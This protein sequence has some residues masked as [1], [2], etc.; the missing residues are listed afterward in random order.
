MS[1]GTLRCTGPGYPL[2][3]FLNA[4]STN[5]GMRSP[6]VM[7]A[8]YFVS[9]AAIATSSISLKPP[10]PWRFRV[11][12]PVTKITGERSPQASIM[13][14]IALA[15]PSGPTRHTV[16]FR[17]I[18]VVPSARCPATC[19]CGQLI[20]LIP[21]WARPSRAG[22]QNP[23]LRVKTWL[24]PF[25]CSERASKTPPRIRSSL[26]ISITRLSFVSQHQAYR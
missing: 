11:L 3:A 25:S 2:S 8:L 12:E 5:S 16:G 1:T 24:M 21:H 20:M 19:S 7:L 23:P 6:S 18:R 4:R 17:V 10:L 15:K 22:L 9:G 26:L 14:G 13:A